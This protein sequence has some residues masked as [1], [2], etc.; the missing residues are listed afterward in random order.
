[1]SSPPCSPEFKGVDR[2]F[3][4]EGITPNPLFTAMFGLLFGAIFVGAPLAALVGCLFLDKW[5]I[6]FVCGY[7]IYVT[8]DASEQHDGRPWKSFAIDFPLFRLLRSHL[9]FSIHI[10]GSITNIYGRIPTTLKEIGATKY[11]FACHPHGVASDYRVIMDGMLYEALPNLDYRTL[12]ASVL[13]KLPIVREV[14]LW[15]RLIDASKEVANRWLE[16]GKSLFIII[17]G[18]AEQMLTQQGKEI[19]FVKKRKGFIKLALKHQARVVPVY[20]FG[21]NHVYRTSNFLL[22]A[23]SWIAKNFRV[24]LPLYWGNYTP[25]DPL[26]YKMDLVMGEP[27]ELFACKELS[28]PTDQ[29]V[30]TAHAAYIKALTALFNERKVELG[31][32][33]LELEV[34]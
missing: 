31:W 12:G 19:C 10:P 5:A 30:D 3:A 22:G 8:Y 23:R 18:E 9:R 4:S 11:I 25:F 16:K 15:T 24:A 32:G 20:V 29:E 1:M 33:D 7:A 27:M 26:P 21:T 14:C 17:G 28:Q 2:I 6:T 34:V 13:F